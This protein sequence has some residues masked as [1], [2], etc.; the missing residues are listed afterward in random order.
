MRLFTFPHEL[1]VE[2]VVQ[3]RPFIRSLFEQFG[4]QISKVV[5]VF[6]RGRR[7]RAPYYLQH[8][9]FHAT[10]KSLFAV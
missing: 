9:I 7:V 4:D 8:Q 6:R 3:R 2:D 10:W 5:G 1:L